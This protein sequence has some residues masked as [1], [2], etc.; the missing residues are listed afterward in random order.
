[1]RRIKCAALA[2]RPAGFADPTP[3]RT[4]PWLAAG[5]LVIALGTLATVFGA[6]AVAANAAQSSRRAQVVAASGIAANLQLV[7]QHEHD[8]VVSASAFFLDHPDASHASFLRWAGEVGALARYPELLGIGEAVVV[9]DSELAAFGE[10]AVASDAGTTTPTPFTVI[11]AGKRPFYCFS[12]TGLAR[13]ALATKPIGEDLCAGVQGQAML[14]ARDSGQPDLQPF[15]IDGIVTLSLGSPMYRGGA[16]PTTVAARRAAFVGW[17]GI[18]I[19]PN[20]ILASALGSHANTEVTLKFGTGAATILFQ[21]GQAPPSSQITSLNLHDGWTVETRTSSTSGNLFSNS[22]ARWLFLTGLLLS[23]L[24]GALIYVLGTGRGRAMQ[25]VHER[26]DELRFQTLHDS[27]TGLP[28]RTLL[29]ERIDRMLA[30]AL[31]AES[32]CAVMFLD[33]DDFKDI[34][35]TLGHEAGDELLIAVSNRLTSALRPG[36]TAGRLGG[37]EFILLIEGAS[38]DNGVTAVANRILNELERP[39]EIRGS[40]IPLSIS[41]SIGIATG[42][43]RA[44]SELLRD[45]DI[46]LYRAKAAGKHRSVIFAPSMQVAVDGHRH[47]DVALK[48]AHVA[49]QFYLLYQPTI[50]LR[51]GDF[52]G[53]EALLRWR[54]PTRGTVQ[55]S[56]FIPALEASGMIVPVGA[57][58]L[59]EA[60]RQGAFWQERGHRFSISVNVSGK[61][62]S[63]DRIVDDVAHALATSGLTPE[64][65]TLELTETSLM[66]NIE[67]TMPRLMLLKALGV[68]IAVDDFGTGYASLAYLR[69]LP[70]DSLKIDRSFVAAMTETSEGAALVHTLVQLGRD[71]HL[72]TVAEGIENDAQ[73]RQVEAEGVDTGQGFLISLPIDAI[74]VNELLRASAATGTRQRSQEPESCSGNLARTGTTA[75]TL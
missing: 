33:L 54:H 14:A 31:R 75:A 17:V 26:T 32:P 27:L 23:G 21:S 73:L 65:L 24:L 7:L 43:R 47:L 58:V 55:P 49:D 60:C 3:L 40:A 29:L 15:T 20:V 1:M 22:D 57:W 4:R 69:Q 12:T 46:A 72:E 16:T 6:N 61:Q 8:L 62:L 10:A 28:N 63:H 36:D 9:P 30:R 5:A 64:M 13:N 52:N 25:L 53:V 39:F 74:A 59:G 38:L 19:L 48:N 56:E 41:A 51:S 37:D 18:S 45:A 70:V 42:A 67:E 2:D 50:D 66:S 68:R 71:L 34:N 35:D 11:P 44:P